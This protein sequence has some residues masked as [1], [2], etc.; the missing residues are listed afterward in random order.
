MEDKLVIYGNFA[1]KPDQDYFAIFDG[2]AGKEASQYCSQF[3]HKFLIAQLQECSHIPTC[4]IQTFTETHESMKQIKTEKGTL[5]ESGATALV[6]LCLGNDLYV[7]NAGDS[8]AVFCRNKKGTIIT[9]D[10]KPNLDREVKRI[11][12]IEGG[13]V[14][15]N[16]VQGKLAVARAIGDFKWNPYVTEIPDIF[17]P[18]NISD[19]S[20]EFLILACD[21]LWDVMDE[22]KACDIVRKCKN[23]RDAA[24]RLRDWAYEERSRDNISVLVVWFPGFVPEIEKTADSI[25]GSGSGTSQSVSAE[26]GNS[27]ESGESGEE[28]DESESEEQHGNPNPNPN[29][30]LV[31][32]PESVSVSVPGSGS[33]SVS[34]PNV[35]SIPTNTFTG[36]TE[37]PPL[38]GSPH[39]SRNGIP[40][41]KV[42]QM[43]RE[44]KAR[45]LYETERL[46]RFQKIQ[47]IALRAKGSGNPSVGI[48]V[49]TGSPHKYN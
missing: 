23:P 47:G 33:R 25:S 16:R 7:A 35:Q 34:G 8:R 21:G 45:A 22:Q 20:Y 29:F 12:A 38:N 31:A 36:S 18:F 1:N 2:H 30:R 44:Q 40:Q 42:A 14:L 6:A 4:L 48:T 39:V 46:A 37:K 41:W 27:R 9:E 3:L 32:G 10:H 24:V 5:T 26:S 11:C 15:K 28:E 43:E 49:L 17:G 13:F 19:P